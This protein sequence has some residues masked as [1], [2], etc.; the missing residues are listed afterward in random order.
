MKS[1]LKTLVAIFFLLMSIPAGADEV[2][3]ISFYYDDAPQAESLSVKPSGFFRAPTI[4]DGILYT[5]A[6]TVMSMDISTSLDIAQNPGKF[7]EMNPLIGQH[8][9]VNTYY[10]IWGG[11]TALNTLLLFLPLPHWMADTFWIGEGSIETVTVEHNLAIGLHF[12]Y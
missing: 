5:W 9:S 7:S 2:R 12:R 8:P 6:E 4:I 3:Q 10:G 1:I 11:M